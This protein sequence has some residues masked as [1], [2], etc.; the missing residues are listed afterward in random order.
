MNDREVVV[1]DV[2]E[3]LLDLT[4]LAQPFSAIMPVELMGL[5]FTRML[6]NSLVAN[7][8]GRYD[9]FDRQGVDALIVTAGSVGVSLSQ[10]AAADF[11]AGLQ[12]LQ[13]HPDVVPALEQLAANGFRLATLTN[14][15][16]PVLEQQM[17]N[18]GLTAFF[19]ELISVEE[20]QLFKPAPATYLYAAGRLR[21]QIDDMRLVAAHSWD[22]TGAARA[23]AKTAYVARG[24]AVIGPLSEAP[25][26]VG[27]DLISVAES[28]IARSGV[29]QGG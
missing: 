13:P 9:A 17:S 16:L 19:D 22:V 27:E 20:V 11:V 4:E 25:D 28:I 7:A 23:G 15:S 2:N 5:W 3:T 14:S 24:T 1:F 8:T 18:A 29:D 12:S 21:V 10:A 6:H 26:I